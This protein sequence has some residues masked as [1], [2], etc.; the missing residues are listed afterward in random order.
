MAQRTFSRVY[1]S[2]R[3]A[4]LATFEAFAAALLEG[5]TGHGHND[6]KLQLAPRAIVRALQQASAGTPQDQAR[7]VIF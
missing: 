7:K 3:A 6:F 5:A 2:R 1:L 4:D